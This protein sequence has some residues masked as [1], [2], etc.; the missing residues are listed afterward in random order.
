M[1]RII[2][3]L[4]RT[5]PDSFIQII[6]KAAQQQGV[7]LGKIDAN[8]FPATSFFAKGGMARGTD[9]VPAML[10]PGEFVMKSPLCKNT[11]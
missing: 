9:T 6:E 10:T 1:Q 11:D 7:Q 4:G 3:G 5:I 2:V 8:T